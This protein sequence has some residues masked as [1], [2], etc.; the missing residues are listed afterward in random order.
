M[1]LPR[2]EAALTGVQIKFDT[3]SVHQ[4]LSLFRAQIQ[5]LMSYM[6][7]NLKSGQTESRKAIMHIEM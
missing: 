4:V 7:D 2:G 3:H 5:S 1:I 6:M